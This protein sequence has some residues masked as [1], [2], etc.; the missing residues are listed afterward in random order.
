MIAMVRSSVGIALAFCMAVAGANPRYFVLTD[1]GNEPDDQMSLVRLL[2]YANEIDI[3]GLVAST[4]TWKKDEL[5]PE[6][7]AEVVDA[8]GE[9]VTN[10]RQHA[11]GWPDADDLKALI[12]SGAAAYGIE[13]M[14]PDD[15]SAGARSLIEAG[16]RD[17]ERPLWVGLWGGA[18]TLAEALA[19]ARSTLD[20]DALARLVDKLRVYSI[21]DQ[22]DAG[23]WLRREFPE[24]FY[25][26][27]PS[28]QDG[29]DYARATWTGI[30]GDEYY[31]NGA[32]ADFTTVS[33][34]WLDEHVRSVGGLGARYP[35]YLFIM[36]GDTPSF[37]GLIPNGLQSGDHP[38]WGGWG[39]R[40]LKRI[41]SGETRPAWTQGGDSFTRITSADTVN[42]HVS[43][44]A[45]IWR[46]REHFQHD[47]AA[48]IDWTVADYQAANHPPAVTVNDHSGTEPLELTLTEGEELR[49]DA[50]SSSDPD[51]DTLTFEF[52]AYPEAGY[53]GEAPPPELTVTPRGESGAD[54]EVAAR[55]AAAWFDWVECPEENVGHVIVA[56]TDSGEPALTRYKRV[57]VTVSAARN[58]AVN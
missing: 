47:F 32:G 25:I 18:N 51:G 45:T 50:S 8:Y 30:A 26:V 48:R 44:Q 38:N 55:C 28:S 41:P 54:I 22:D 46:W 27:S 36:E 13:G 21:S 6:M 37:L 42:G 12:G 2:L 34:E 23:P 43:D 39:G 52:I 11:D 58:S 7:I 53:A 9:V 17:D 49:L 56:V 40:Y 57:L 5:S 19:H 33:N 16:L 31:R 20:D 24:L 15:P 35:E 4:S 10:L 1:I 14:S 29:G 3:E